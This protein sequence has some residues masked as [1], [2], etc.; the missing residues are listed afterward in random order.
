MTNSPL[1]R[2]NNILR[3]EKEKYEDKAVVGGL[4]QY[5]DTWQKQADQTFGTEAAGWVQEVTERLRT[6]SSLPDPQARRKAIAALLNVLDEAPPPR[7][8]RHK[9]QEPPQARKPSKPPSPKKSAVHSK[10]DK[11]VGVDASVTELRGVGPKRSERLARLGIH[12]IRDVLYFL[13]RRYD[14]YSQLKPINRLEYG[15]EVSIIARV[16]RANVR[17][18]RSG[19]ALF[20]IVLSDGSGSIEATWFNQ[21]YLANKIRRGQQIVISGKVDQ[22]LGRLCFNSPEWEPLDKELLHTGRIVPI[23]PLTEGISGKWLRNLM[24]RTVTYWSRRLPDYLPESVRQAEDLLDLETAIV[25]AHFPESQDLLRRARYRLAFGELFLLQIGLLRRKRDWRSTPGRALPVDDTVLPTFLERLPYELTDAQ[26]RALDQIVS[27]LQSQQPMNRLLQGDVGSGKTVVAAAAMALVVEAGA[28]AA[29]MAPTQILA[30]QHYR[31]FDDLLGHNANVRLLT[32]SITGQARD[33]IYTGLADGSIDIA[34]GTHALI[35]QEV[36]FDDLAL[37][38]IDEQHRFGVHQRADL[39]QKGIEDGRDTPAYEPDLLVMTATPIPRSLQLTLWGHLDVSVI[40]EMPPGREP[41]ATR[42]IL[43][44]ER[45]RAYAFV[46]SQIE[47][48]RQAFII[49]PLVEESEKIEAKAAVEEYER[50]QRHIFPDLELGLLHGRMS[51]EEKETIMAQFAQGEIDILVATSVIE[52]GID[53]PN[54]TVMLIEGADRFGLAQ[55]HQFRGRVGRGGHRSYC[56]LVSDS[57][58]AQAQ[59]RLQTVESTNDGFELAQKDL[60][61]RGPGEFLGTRQSGLPDL[62]LASIADLRTVEAAREAAQRFFE[63]DPKLNKPESRPLVEQLEQ[64]WEEG[65]IS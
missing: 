1:E 59:E 57:S 44:T 7:Q 54:A 27:D 61:M 40:D 55:L 37:S 28:Q 46:R 17:K 8:T 13:P 25:Q 30:E 23:Y 29:L 5:A 60:E 9:R 6:Y 58:A 3:L 22:Y 50:L 33:E 26:Q 32:G 20:Q 31:T 63:T 34:I 38:V 64:F 56:L 19:G 42:L 18:T 2:L 48:G 51:G 49:C 65:E 45:E 35:Q 47:E 12:T 4:E 39:R 11:K 21:P 41:V 43:P 16:E 10:S 52:V 24:R 53:V 62:K 14:D 15:E 36:T